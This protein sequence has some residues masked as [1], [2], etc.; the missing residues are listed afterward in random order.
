VGSI[1]AWGYCPLFGGVAS[2]VDFVGPA[3][4]LAD[5]EEL[6]RRHG[7]RFRPPELLRT[8]ARE[9]RTLHAA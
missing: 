6:A 1:L 9:N 3:R 4:L 7:P 5:C 8:L 2:Y